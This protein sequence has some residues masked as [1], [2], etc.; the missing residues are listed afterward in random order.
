MSGELAVIGADKDSANGNGAGAAY[1]FHRNPS[2]GTWVESQKLTSSDGGPGQR[3]GV[4]VAV[5][6]EFA[7]VAAPDGFFGFA[8]TVGPGAAHV[9]GIDRDSDGLLDRTEI[10]LA[11]GTGCPDF[12]NPDSD[13]DSLLDGAEVAIGTNP[14]DPDTDGDGLP[15]DL[16][17]DP[18]VPDLI[19]P[20][21][22]EL[23]VLLLA[24][25]IDGID[26]SLFTGPN[27]N[28]NA[29]RRNALANR[30]QKAAKSLASGDTS[31]AIDELTSL[32]ERVDGVSP[33]PDWVDDSS[34]KTTLAGN[35]VLLINLLL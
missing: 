27:N 23:P 30:A 20:G 1:V 10:D 12:R 13:G 8:T 18:L 26:L 33:P 34:E 24:A 15:D 29:G 28:A 9:F 31:A 21:T 17:P 11:L 2:S 5:S 22:L 6:E 14:C 35:L 19:T 32:L 3:M 16:D 7:V 4:S 25:Q